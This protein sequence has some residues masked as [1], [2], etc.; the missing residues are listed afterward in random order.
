MEEAPSLGLFLLHHLDSLDEEEDDVIEELFEKTCG[1]HEAIQ[2]VTS[3]KENGNSLFKVTEFGRAYAIYRNAMKCLCVT[4]SAIYEECSATKIDPDIRK[5]V[6]SLQ[7]NIAACEIKLLLFKEAISSCSLV[8]GVDKSNVK[9]LFRRGV[10]F[11]KIESFEAGYADFRMAR[12]IEPNNKAVAQEIA[13]I[14]AVL[15]QFPRADVGV[16]QAPVFSGVGPHDATGPMLLN[17]GLQAMDLDVQEEVTSNFSLVNSKEDEIMANQDT[18]W[19]EEV[20]SDCSQ[21]TGPHPAQNIR[22]IP[23]VNKRKPSS[24]LMISPTDL[25]KLSKGKVIQFCQP[26]S[27]SILK[28]RTFTSKNGNLK[29]APRDSKLRV[30]QASAS[31]LI[32]DQGHS[33]V[34]SHLPSS[35][36]DDYQPSSTL[37]DMQQHCEVG[38]VGTGNLTNTILSAGI[39]VQDNLRCLD[40]SLKEDITN[41]QF[42][43]QTTSRLVDKRRQSIGQVVRLAKPCFGRKFRKK[44][45]KG[46][47][48]HVGSKRKSDAPI[49]SDLPYHV[50]KKHVLFI[51]SCCNVC[52][53][54]GLGQVVGSHGLASIADTAPMIPDCP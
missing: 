44:I 33:G 47:I 13:S 52:T 32:E 36:K 4:I 14:E 41:V 23:F 53:C 12:G 5:L 24:R 28:V 8:L 21:C 3:L 54:Q 40:P 29:E 25:D 1:P 37:Q 51:C 38:K 9:A 26:H 2:Y 34:I 31:A 16:C 20:P 49:S 30:A 18:K 42:T 35:P 15:L 45:N 27:L 39:H 50:R 22:K 17:P 11:T 19:E 7:L 10:S 46:V 43:S 6:I 48:S